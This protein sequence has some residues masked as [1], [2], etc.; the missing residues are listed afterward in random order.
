MIEKYSDAHNFRCFQG[1]VRVA[2]KL[3]LPA[4]LTLGLGAAPLTGPAS[5]FVGVPGGI[6]AETVHRA[7]DLYNDANNLAGYWLNVAGY[8]G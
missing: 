4:A 7:R 2:Q 5:S 8:T 1:E 6:D 3:S